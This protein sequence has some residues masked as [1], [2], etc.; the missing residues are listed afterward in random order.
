[1]I[2]TAA[3][4]LSKMD[5]TTYKTIPF[6]DNY[7]ISKDGIVIN[8]K[9]K[10]VKKPSINS[11]GYCNMKLPVDGV[12]KTFT[13]HRLV[14][15]LYLDNPLNYEQINHINGIKTDNNLSNLEW[16]SRQQNMK[17]ACEIGLIDR[18][19]SKNPNAKFTEQQVREIKTLLQQKVKHRII[20]EQYK[21]NRVLITN[22][23]IGKT[24]KHI[25]L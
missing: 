1:M 20:A 2:L 7:A 5:H 11:K 3:M 18:K 24:W 23:S 22:I 19:G 14:A 13:V 21:T 17:H 16:C 12:Q 9:F 15:M 8:K 4:H 25:T 10:K 6:A